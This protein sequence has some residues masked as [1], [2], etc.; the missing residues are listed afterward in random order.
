MFAVSRSN[1]FPQKNFASSN[2]TLSW[3][4]NDKTGALLVFRVVGY[5]ICLVGWYCSS[6]QFHEYLYTLI[7]CVFHMMAY[8]KLQN[9][10]S[11]VQRDYCSPFATVAVVFACLYL[12]YYRIGITRYQLCLL[13]AGRWR[14]DYLLLFYNST[15]RQTFSE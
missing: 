7:C 14:L 9:I 2:K 12:E 6:N 4:Q 3:R 13:C 5:L 15:N 8:F 10:F 1:Q 11:S